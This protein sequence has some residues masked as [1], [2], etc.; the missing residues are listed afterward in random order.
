MK[1]LGIIPARYASSRFPG[2]PLIDIEGKTMIQ[3]VYEQVKKSTRLDE[4]VVATDDQRIA[5]N[6]LS[7]GG[8]VVMTAPHHQSGT[9]RCAEVITQMPGYDI[10][11]N[12][13]GDEPFINPAQIDLLATCFEA[14]DTQIA[15]LVM[16]ITLEQELFNVNI[17]KVVRNTKGEAIFFSRQ[18]IPFLRAVEKDQ[19]L[20]RQTFYKHI[21]IYAY[22]VDT[23][24][25]L[26]QLP[27]SM[28]EE[29]EALEQLRWLENGYAIQTAITTH[30]TVAVDTKEDLS[31]ILRLFF[32]K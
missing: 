8:Q 24:K 5:D 26:T 30:E 14:P 22:Q 15:T 31:K 7:F 28:L 18:T 20:Q 2:K 32:N 29:A 6:V 4:V 27:I 9:D 3:R 12:I 10:V 1:F 17:P 11:I 23:L 13:Q 19:W 25:A 21:G 16:E